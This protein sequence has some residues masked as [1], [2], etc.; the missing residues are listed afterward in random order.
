MIFADIKG[1]THVAEDVLT[2]NCMGLLSILSSNHLI[3]FLSKSVNLEGKKLDLSSFSEIEKL[4]FWPYLSQAGEPDI[5]CILKSCSTK[6]RVILI[7]ECKHG[8]GKSGY[9]TIGDEIRDQLGKYYVGATKIYPD[10]RV[11]VIYLTHH[12]S[13]PKEEIKESISITGNSTSILLAELVS[14]L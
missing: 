10:E 12:R 7:I 3:S 2:S 9:G 5:L 14:S 6:Q 1:K 11:F 8:A 4:E 13:F